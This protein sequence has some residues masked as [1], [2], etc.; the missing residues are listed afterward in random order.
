MRTNPP[1]PS[2]VAQNVHESLMYYASRS[3]PGGAIVEIGVYKGG[4]AWH[5]ARLRRPLYLY[6]TFEGM[7]VS[8][9]SDTHQLG[10]FSDCSAEAVQEA[11]PSAII[12]KGKFPD[13]LIEMPPVSFVHADADQYESTKAI[14]DLMPDRML[15]GG[16]I[17][18]DDFMVKDCEGCT[19]AVMESGRR[20]LVI[21]ETG[22][23]L[24]IV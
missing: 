20:I 15:L 10:H 13:S 16:F 14:L 5:L 23:A 9:G 2:L 4:T 12:I 21:G 7:P 3:N 19:Q 6:D 8:S 18:F 11:I 22:R 17:L 24:V 1:P